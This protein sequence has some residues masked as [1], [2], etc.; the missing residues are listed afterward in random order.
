MIRSTEAAPGASTARLH[1]LDAVRGGALLLGV[2]FHA[3]LSFLEPRIWIVGDRA[4]SVPLTVT[5]FVLHLFRMTL[6]FLMAGFFARMLVERRGVGGF[7]RDRAK[8]ILL[9]LLLFWPPVFAALA[10]VTIWSVIDAAGRTL[11]ADAPPAPPLT[12]AGF[13]L[14]HLW[15][16]YVLSWFYAGAL[17]L[18]VTARLVD[19]GG[20]F[21]RAMDAGVR[22]VVRF[23]VEAAVLGAPVAAALWL[24]PDWIM[25]FGVPT[26]DTGLL[27]NTPALAAYGGAFCFGWLLNRQTGL[28]KTWERSWPSNLAVGAAATGACLWL[29]GLTP[30]LV[31]A[32][33]D[34]HKAVFAALYV[35]AMWA[36]ATGLIGAAM[37]HLSDHGVVRR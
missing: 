23:R 20:G 13:P 27:P 17:A 11:P 35:V 3:T 36:W 8:R 6:F 19:R 2:I 7:V 21:R 10:T 25:W 22:A 12:A 26:P 37:K 29:A 16:L 32:A 15:F 34:W 14:T 18:H 4:T 31:P 28:M 9:P 5:F 24:K 1:A 33:Q 30:R